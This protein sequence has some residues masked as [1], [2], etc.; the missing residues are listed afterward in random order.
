MRIRSHKNRHWSQLGLS[1]KGL[2]I[3]CRRVKAMGDTAHEIIAAER[4]NLL[5]KYTDNCKSRNIERIL[6]S[7]YNA[8]P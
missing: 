3:K 7:V 1:A 8:P 4:K 2:D 6:I 5:E